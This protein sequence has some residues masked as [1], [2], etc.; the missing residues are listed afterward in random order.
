MLK[1]MFSV[2]QI[3]YSKFI[4]TNADPRTEHNTDA[5]T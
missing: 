3:S 5:C 2:I 1:T 4:E